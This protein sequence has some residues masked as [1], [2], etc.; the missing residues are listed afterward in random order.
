MS[1]VDFVTCRYALCNVTQVVICYRHVYVLYG[2]HD[3]THTYFVVS[4]ASFM[5]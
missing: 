2:F 3:S 5:F 1:S 4:Y